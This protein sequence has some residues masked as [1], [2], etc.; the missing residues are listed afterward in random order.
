M[1]FIVR[2]NRVA[3]GSHVVFNTVVAILML[4]LFSG[5]IVSWISILA[6]LEVHNKSNYH[7][8][9]YGLTELL[10]ECKVHPLNYNNH[11]VQIIT[12][13]ETFVIKGNW[14]TEEQLRYITELIEQNKIKLK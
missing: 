5:F 1:A 10:C 6:M 9:N 8:L 12:T 3:I 7:V 4:L 2:F 11:G 13:N 14:V